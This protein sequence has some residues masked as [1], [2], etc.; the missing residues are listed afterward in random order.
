MDVQG[1]VEGEVQ[2]AISRNVLGEANFAVANDETARTS[3]S[4]IITE[5]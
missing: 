1:V 5:N 4:D 3:S 2:I